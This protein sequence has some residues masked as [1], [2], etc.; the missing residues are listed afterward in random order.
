M[1][2]FKQLFSDQPGAS[3]GR[4]GSFLALLAG[5]VWVTD[6]VWHTKALPD[7]SGLTFFIGSLYV[8]GKGVGTVRAIFGKEGSVEGKESEV[9]SQKSE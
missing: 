2:F 7:F 6:I 3:F 1:N 4:F 9:R 5:I 8:L